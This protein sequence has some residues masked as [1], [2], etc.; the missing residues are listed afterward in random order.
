M[1]HR[2]KILLGALIT[3]CFLAIGTFG[4]TWIENYPI[5]DA[6]YMTVITI[7][8][9]GFGEIHVLSESGRIFTIFLILFG[10]GSLGFLA[11]AFT[12][13]II[14]QAT[15]K[16]LGMK[17]M[18]KRI[19]QLKR[20][21]I[22]CG[23]GRV[24]E[25]AADHFDTAGY[26]FV[27]IENSEEQLKLIKDSNYHYLEGDA[28]R[29]DTLL[30]AGIKNATALLALL[31]SDPEN[32]FTVL[33]ARELNPTLQIIARSEIAS[34]ESR[35]LRAGADSII[36][37]YV[38]AG[39]RVAEK[40]LATASKHSLTAHPAVEHGPGPHWVQVTEQSSDLAGH[41]VETA[42]TF[43]GGHIIGIR[44]GGI[45]M[46]MPQHE[47]KIELGDELLLTHAA[48][49]GDTVTTYAGQTKKLVLVD[50]NPVILRLYTRLF[51]KAGFHVMTA[52][53]GS[54]GC[55]LILA[56]KPAAAVVDY[57]LPDMSG[58]DVCRKLRKNSVLDN[59]KLFLFTA[60]EEEDLKLTAMEA[61]IDAVVVKSP[62]ASEIV[63]AVRAQ[64]KDS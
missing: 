59:V 17:T 40:I 14:E 42:N 29:E 55:S 63:N 5:I 23:F 22:I 31:N 11:H 49:S 58:I 60:N 48:R 52:T 6:F 10:F 38:S 41:V 9:V 37:P 45:D 36:S 53:H 12:E 30:A 43:L 2:R 34:S 62:D 64:L 15:S 27:V 26:D 54:S 47:M 20:H 24:G 51:Q 46:L 18:K 35:M 13:A 19:L 3:I 16:H 50:D 7:S 4:Y 56:E 21:V 25:A 32:L 33:T 8:T 28:T 1:G 57:E 44:R 39:R 61:G